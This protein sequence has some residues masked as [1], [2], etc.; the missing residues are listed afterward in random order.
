MEDIAYSF[1]DLMDQ[2]KVVFLII[3][4][5]NQC[6]VMYSSKYIELL[7]LQQ[8]TGYKKCCVCIEFGS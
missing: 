3:F 2:G 7:C 5:E 6:F 8:K 4:A 1:Q